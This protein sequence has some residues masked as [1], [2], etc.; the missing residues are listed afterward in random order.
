[1]AMGGGMNQK[2]NVTRLDL[3]IAHGIAAAIGLV[4]GLITRSVLWGLMGFTIG[5]GLIGTLLGLKPKR[6]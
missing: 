2:P 5:S 1:M 6:S 3:W 4:V